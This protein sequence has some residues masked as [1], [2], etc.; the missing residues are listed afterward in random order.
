MVE[1]RGEITDLR[2]EYISTLVDKGIVNSKIEFI[3][4]KITED[5]RQNGGEKF[6]GR[7]E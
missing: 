6:D 3:R 5:M 4:M 7:T 2:D 1:I